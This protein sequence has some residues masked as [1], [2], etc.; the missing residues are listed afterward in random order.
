MN[1]LLSQIWICLLLAALI[2]GIIGWILRGGCKKKLAAIDYDWRNRY[3]GIEV[4]RNELTSRLGNLDNVSQERDQLIREVSSLRGV[5]QERDDL[6][7]KLVAFGTGT[8]SVSVEPSSDASVRLE[9]PGDDTQD[10]YDIEEVE[11]IGKGYGKRLRAM[12]IEST[13]DLFTHCSNTAGI[14]MVAKDIQMEDEVVRSWTSM[15]DLMRVKGIGGQYAELLEYS[16]VHTTQMLAGSDTSGLTMKMADVNSRENRVR[17]TPDEATVSTWIAHAKTL[18]KVLDDDIVSLKADA[19][20]ITDTVAISELDISSAISELE[21]NL[22]GDNQSSYDIEEVEGVGK[23]YGR[24]LREM[25]IN[26]TTD[27]IEKCPDITSMKSVI[28]TMN[29]EDWVIRSWTSMADLMRVRGIGGQYAELLN[30]SDIA[31]VQALAKANSAGLAEKMK[32]VNEKEHRVK[33]APS[34]DNIA[35]WIEHA[36]T[37]EA[38]LNLD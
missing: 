36:K 31:S 22:V 11:G 10:S 9:E 25:G 16:S 17:S 4:E 12:N 5:Q 37:L 30:F 33:Q 19:R 15:A 1:Y 18:S 8:A 24:K 27:L 3:A 7:A 21:D 6:S 20:T 2:G 26:T 32:Q 35:G 38:L 23:G 34:R 14:Q 13:R 29:L 28:E